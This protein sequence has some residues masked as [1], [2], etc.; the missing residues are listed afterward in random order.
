MTTDDKLG[1]HPGDAKHKY[2]RK[3]DHDERRA[4]VMTGHVRKAP[5]VAQAHCRARRGKHHAYLR[6][7]IASFHILNHLKFYIFSNDNATKS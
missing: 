3:I 6:T 7:K 2:T 5:D 4:T 1:D